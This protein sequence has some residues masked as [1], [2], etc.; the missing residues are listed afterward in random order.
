M[1]EED[2]GVGGCQES[3]AGSV[4]EERVSAGRCLVVGVQEGPWEKHHSGGLGCRRMRRVFKGW[5]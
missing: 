2:R 1:K 4:P 5:V 3:P